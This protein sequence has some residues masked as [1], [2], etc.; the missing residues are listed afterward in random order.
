MTARGC[1]TWL[2]R[3]FA[4]DQSGNMA[5]LF[6]ATT[7]LGLFAATMA[8]DTA[9]LYL[10][11]RQAQSAVDLAAMTAAR[12]PSNA[13][14]IARQVL[15]DARMV[16]AQAQLATLMAGSGGTRLRVTTGHYSADPALT[17]GQR[18]NANATT[19]NAVRVELE[20][21]GTLVFGQPWAS[22]PSIG[23]SALAS[24]T[25][26]VSFSVGTRLLSL[27]EG[28]ANGL[29]N[30]LLGANVS[31]SAAS[32][33]ALVGA[34]VQLFGFM[35][36]LAQ[37][38]GVTAGTYDDLLDMKADHG[39]IARAMARNLGGA[40]H[41]AAALLGGALGSNGRVRIGDLVDLGDMARLAVGSS[42]QSPLQT[43]RLGALDLLTASAALSDGSHQV[44][45]TLSAGVPGLTGLT[46]RLAVGEP[47]Q[48]ATWFAIGPSGTLVRTAQ[49]RVKVVATLGGSGV[50]AGIGVRVPLYLELA[51]AEAG[52]HSAIC[53]TTGA[54]QGSATIRVKPAVARLVLGE[55]NDAAIG[56]FGSK[57]VPAPAQLVNALLLRISG[58]A[59]VTLANTEPTLI[60]FSPTEITAGTVKSAHATG[61]VSGM[62]RRL[63]ETLTL[64]IDVLGLGLA[65]VPVLD[66][67]VKTLVTPLGPVVDATLDT[68]LLALGLK[69]G[70]ADVRVYSV[71]CATPALVG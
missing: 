56:H 2:I 31:V 66:A 60:T 24:A 20:R 7:A 68:L 50:L 14:E 71:T 28:L 9:S 46:M 5:M 29:L 33:S 63:M 23:V 49:A 11:R 62:T 61:M 69:L 8:I 64:D 45:M 1:L 58:H 47:E 54:S 48:G 43:V 55:V 13:A 10:E 38:M 59:E 17:P 22:A 42:G 34:K 39:Q 15:V 70:E 18:F 30:A 41:A 37:E 26:Q 40:D 36:A 32:Y 6:S 3:R 4:A 44:A 65:P 12:N 35:D 25:P 51:S 67:A 52:V 19:R 53:P 27:H 57:P 16:D 21:P